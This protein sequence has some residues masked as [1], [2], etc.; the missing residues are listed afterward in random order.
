LPLVRAAL[1]H[2]VPT[3]PDAATEYPVV[4]EVVD[5]YTV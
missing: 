2:D 5:W 1:V 4:A 3:T